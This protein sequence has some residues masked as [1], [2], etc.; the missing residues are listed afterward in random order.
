MTVLGV[1]NRRT[2]FAEIQP[3]CINNINLIPLSTCKINFTNIKDAIIY[4]ENKV[5]ITNATIYDST[6]YQSLHEM[7]YNYCPENQ[8]EETKEITKKSMDFI[9]SS[10]PKQDSK[11]MGA[12]FN[13]FDVYKK[14]TLERDKATENTGNFCQQKYVDYM[15]IDTIK[16]DFTTLSDK[17]H[18]SET[19]NSV[20]DSINKK[21]DTVLWPILDEEI[22]KAKAI[23][24]K[25]Q[26]P[27]MT[28]D[29][30]YNIYYKNGTYSKTIAEKIVEL[31]TLIINTS[32]QNLV[33]KKVLTTADM[34]ALDKKIIVK[35]IPDCRKTVWS[36]IVEETINQSNKK[37]IQANVRTI[38]LNVNICFNYQYIQ[39]IR[40]YIEQITVH[41]LGHYVYYIKD[42]QPESFE[43]IC[44]KT[45]KITCP[46]TQ[47]ISSY[48]QSWPEEDYAESF[49][50]RYLW[51][52]V[53]KEIY[54]GSYYSGN[55]YSGWY[56]KQTKP[57]LSSK[58]NYFTTLFK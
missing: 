3:I 39:N 11:K 8:T 49:L 19:Q 48:A 43:K 44:R 13:F 36:T 4:L 12:L 51:D 7:L 41:E 18:L 28:K 52:T 29:L 21:D 5:N 6:D 16:K 46:K 26:K 53:T 55:Y 54:S 57:I 58:L 32:I 24:I 10:L 2:T 22:S 47:F 15:I 20:F 35:Y 17:R 34:A 25:Q 27:T 37:R 31:S 1:Y 56:I 30:L 50:H 38:N 42:N 33:D 14:R 45:N 23:D 9:T 40:S